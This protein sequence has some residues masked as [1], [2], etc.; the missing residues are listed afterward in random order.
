MK[1]RLFVYGTLAPGEANHHWMEPLAGS[2]EVATAPG[3]VEQQTT[4]VHTGLPCF[5]PSEVDTV[6]GMIFTSEELWKIWDKLDEFEGVD[7][8]RQLIP[9]V[10]AS[11]AKVDAFVYVDLKS[12][13]P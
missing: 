10:T 2:W 1:E 9:V 13:A 12:L 3:R 4:G 6:S 5:I 11:G 7:Y 8:G